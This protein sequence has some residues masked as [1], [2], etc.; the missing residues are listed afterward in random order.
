MDIDRKKSG[1]SCA[2]TRL[3]V[4]AKRIFSGEHVSINP[5]LDGL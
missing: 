3:M 4:V 1:G 5:S 2:I